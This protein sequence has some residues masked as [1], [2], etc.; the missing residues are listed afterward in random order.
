MKRHPLFFLFSIVLSICFVLAGCS[1]D[2]K[3]S[4]ELI[5][6][7]RIP[8]IMVEDVLYLDTGKQI[9]VEIEDTSILGTISSDVD[10]TEIPAEN[11]QSNFGCVGS[12]YAFYEDGVVVMIDN[13]WQ[14][15]RREKSELTLDDV[16]ELAKKKDSLSWDDFEKYEGMEIGS[17][18]YILCYD[19]DEDFYLLIGGGSK[20]AAPMYIRLVRDGTKDDSFDLLTDDDVENFISKRTN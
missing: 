18:L 12:E 11:G 19:I 14:F 9:P 2:Q 6:W 16:I 10:A 5:Q 20:D 17:G 1:K 15:F 3:T 7:D 4:E 13:E 8:T